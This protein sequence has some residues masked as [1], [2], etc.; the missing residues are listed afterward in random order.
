SVQMKERL[1]E[2]MNAQNFTAVKFAEIM[3]VQP[4]NISH[5]MSGRN[6]PNF[7][8]VAR[9]LRRFPEVNPDWLINGFGSMYRSGDVNFVNS[10]VVTDVKHENFTDNKSVNVINEPLFTDVKTLNAF[11]PSTVS[12]KNSYTSSD[13]E[14]KSSA[15]EIDASESR[16]TELPNSA[17]SAI[18]S[19]LKKTKRVMVFYDDMSCEIYSVKE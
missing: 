11:E 8:F 9:M 19:D 17:S 1:L 4:S 12:S 15:V 16:T 18:N 13:A 7:D 6:N 5:I 10:S 14:C 2:F 3:E